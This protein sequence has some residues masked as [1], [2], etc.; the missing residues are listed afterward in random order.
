MFGCV[1]DYTYHLSRALAEKGMEVYVLTSD[2]SVI[3]EDYG[4]GDK[5]YINVLYKV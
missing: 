1:F 5:V 2:E 4:V 3:R